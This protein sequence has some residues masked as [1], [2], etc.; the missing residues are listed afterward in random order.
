MER[1]DI[2]F[3]MLV[4]QG[5]KT[6]CCSSQSLC[7]FPTYDVGRGEPD[8]FSGTCFLLLGLLITGYGSVPLWLEEL[9]ILMV[10]RQEIADPEI[11]G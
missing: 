6:V 10:K 5:T 4:L 9:P 8:W 7:A 11:T 1:F 3:A 2:K